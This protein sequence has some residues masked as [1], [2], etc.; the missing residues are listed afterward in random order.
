MDHHTSD[1]KLT[2]RQQLR[3][4]RRRLSKQQQ[5]SAAIAIDRVIARSGMLKRYRS[6]ALY[7]ANDGEIDPRIL[8]ARLLRQGIQ[9]YLPIL[10]PAGTLWFARYR[11]GDEL[12]VNPFGI[13]EPH[14]RLRR[15][16][17]WSLNLV[18]LPLV[19]FDKQG[20]R[21]GMGGGFYDRTFANSRRHNTLAW[22]KLVGLA[23]HCQ[24]VD[25]LDKD[26]WDIPLA[27]I[28]TDHEVIESKK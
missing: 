4:R 21:L 5:M 11:K 19:G 27:A 26:S 18:L 8:L 24:E 14:K 7:M 10:N 6:V 16:K 9:C 28:A 25:Q 17:A 1:H 13:L 22:P 15:H 23:H 12:F 2:L 3:H 20:N